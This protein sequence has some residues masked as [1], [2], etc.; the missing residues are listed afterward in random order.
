[1]LVHDDALWLGELIPIDVALIHKI[2]DLPDKG[3]D[4]MADFGGKAQEKVVAKY[5]S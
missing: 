4:L 3:A 5:Q 1:M 2:I